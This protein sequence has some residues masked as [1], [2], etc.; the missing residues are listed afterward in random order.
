MSKKSRKIKKDKNKKE[1]ETGKIPH[2]TISIHGNSCMCV[3]CLQNPHNDPIDYC[4]RGSGG[5]QPCNTCVNKKHSFNCKC[6][7][8]NSIIGNGAK[9]GAMYHSPTHS[10]LTKPH[11]NS[12]PVPC[13]EGNTKAFK[14]DGIQV[15]GGG[16]N[17]D[18]EPFEVDVVID[19]THGVKK[20]MNE[21]LDNIPDGWKSKEKIK[22]NT[23]VLDFYLQD[24]S[25]PDNATREFWGLLWKDLKGLKKKG[26]TLNVLVMCLGGH[27][28]TGT[29]LTALLMASG[30]NKT[31]KG[32]PVVWLRK[33]YCSKAVESKRQTDYLCKLWP[34]DIKFVE[35]IKGSGSGHGLGT[36]PSF[37]NGG[38]KHNSC[39][40][41]HKTPSNTNRTMWETTI[42]GYE[43]DNCNFKRKK[44]DEEKPEE[45]SDNI[46]DDGE[47]ILCGEKC[48]ERNDGWHHTYMEDC[49]EDCNGDDCRYSVYGENDE[50]VDDEDIIETIEHTYSN[51]CEAKKGDN[52]SAPIHSMAEVEYTESAL[53]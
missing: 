46:G 28:R 23:L 35:P 34:N 22:T 43:C 11:G 48:V 9:P 51:G 53:D 3:N 17:H 4:R 18:A 14:K 40:T 44:K 15:W 39:K 16:T 38:S 2:K 24:M 8:C 31:V 37:Y 32:N 20:S 36:G 33:N 26:K 47:G 21:W 19:L 25:S 5:D 50:T 7:V 10:Q 12:I 42:G 29:V 30:Y 52:H 13:H 49:T 45:E 6:T 27:G 1:E 41:C